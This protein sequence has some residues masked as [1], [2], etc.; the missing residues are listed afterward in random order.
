[1]ALNP[2]PSEL[3]STQI[4]QRSFDKDNDAI[5]T[6]IVAGSISFT[7][8]AIAAP[9]DPAPTDVK[10]AGGVD[11]TDTTRALHTD[12][13]GDLQIDVLS[14]VLPTGAATEATLAALSAKSAGALVSE[15]FDYQLVTY[16]GLT[17]DIN[18]VTYKLGGAG[19]T[20]VAQISL[21]YDGSGRLSTVTKT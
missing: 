12:T 11:D 2:T 8:E 1:M 21:G 14:S 4:N 18:T 20:T 7:E 17:T 19:G 15:D 9:G 10:V 6:N 5:R 16:V 13:D 3:S